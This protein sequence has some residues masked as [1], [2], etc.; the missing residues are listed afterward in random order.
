MQAPA[1]IPLGSTFQVVI[2]SSFKTPAGLTDAAR[3]RVVLA[4]P[5]FSTHGSRQGMRNV[6]LAISSVVVS[7]QPDSC[8]RV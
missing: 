7:M 2:T 8:W 1:T 4:H 6:I 5:G 3:F